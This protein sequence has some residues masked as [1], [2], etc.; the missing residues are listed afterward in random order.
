MKDFALRLDEL[1]RREFLAGVAK[2]ALGVGILP[3]LCG[4][5]TKGGGYVKPVNPKAKNVV[6]VY[7]SGGM[8]HLDT[9]DPKSNSEVKGISGPIKTNADGVQVS[10]LLPN[11][12]KHGNKLAILRTMGQKTGAHA[13]GK[14]LMHTAFAMRPGTSHPQ[15]GS[16]A[17]Y[18]LGRRSRSMPDSVLIGAGN[19]GP[20][21]FPPDHAPFPIGDASKGIRDLL[22]KIDR[23]V[24]NHRVQL[25]QRFSRVFEKYFPH[26]EVKA[27]A[28]F[29]DETLKFFDSKT[30]DAFDI[31]KEA[32]KARTLY[33][34][35]KFGRGLLL[36]RRLLEH[37]VRYIEVTLG[38]WDGM[39]NGMN[40]GE[41]RTG[42]LDAPF[43]AFLGDLDQR[44]LLK[45]TMVV[46]TTEFGRT[47]KINQ[48]GGRDHFPGAF[49]AVLAGGGVN[50]GQVI[51][52]TDEKGIKRAKGDKISPQ[53]LH[54]TIAHALGLPVD[55]RIHGSGGR[56]FF[57]GN[58]GSVIKQVFA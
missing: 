29:Y 9:F 2:T 37:K 47:P 10:K 34:T 39:H 7:M 54:T 32:P 18:F 49:S 1:Q 41:Q 28:Q 53:D 22:P 14:Y 50:G 45:E 4:A 40:A 43:A 23:K 33:G 16:W 26:D 58:Q 52:Q 36:A 19:P 3:S 8:S 44:G 51:G 38:G 17:Q 13:Q 55:E 42:E 21:F 24:F 25:A 27:Y 6:F 35:S 57:V 11:I 20:G 46:L 48:R 30:V 15:L 31:N 56:P 5:A 12:A